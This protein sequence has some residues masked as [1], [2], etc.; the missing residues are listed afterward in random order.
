MKRKKLTTIT[1]ALAAL[2]VSTAL[3]GELMLKNTSA[4]EVATYELSTIFSATD[5]T[6]GASDSK[7][8]AFTLSDGGSVTFKR[9]L[10]Y[11][12]Y[13]AANTANYLTMKFAFQDTKFDAVEFEFDAP[14]AWATKDD[15]TTNVVQFK[16]A[17]DDYLVS[18]NGMEATTV[19]AADIA[20]DMT[21][22]LAEGTVDGEFTV[23]LKVGDTAAVMNEENSKFVNVGANYATYTYGETLPLTVSAVMPTSA[24]SDTTVVLFKELN[25]QK[26]DALTDENKIEDKTAPVLVV[27]E[28]IDGFLL[29]SAFALD[30]TVVDVLKKDS[31]TKNLTYYQYDP[32]KEGALTDEDYKTLDTSVYFMDTVFTDGETTTSVFSK[33]GQ[34]YV[35]VKAEIGDG[36][37]T[38][39]IDLS[40][41]AKRTVNTIGG[42]ETETPYIVIDRNTEGAKYVYVT[43]KESTQTNDF[44]E[45]AFEKYED[46]ENAGKYKDEAVNSFYE[47]LEEATKDVTAGS[48]SYVYFPSFKWFINDNNGYRNLKFTISYKT[49]S[50]SSAS[51]STGLSHSALKLAVSEEGT[52]QFKIF[53]T[54]KAGNT[55]KYY[56]ED[57]ELVDI[58]TDNVWDIEE[59]PYFTFS[60]DNQGLKV[61]DPSKASD[62]KDSVILNKTYTMDEIDVVGAS[63]MQESYSLYKVDMNAYNADAE[64]GRKLTQSALSAVSYEDIAT[65]LQTFKASGSAYNAEY[66]KAVE[67]KNYY[68]VYLL[69]YSKLLAEEIGAVSTDK[70]VVEKIKS[71]FVEIK[72]YDARINEENGATEWEAYNKY[73]WTPTSKSFSTVEEGSFLIVADYWEKLTPAVRAAA[74]KVIVVESEAD[75]IKGE[76]DWLKNNVVSVVLFSVAGVM[77]ILIIILLLVKPSDETLEDVDAKAAAKKKEAKNKK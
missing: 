63:N 72:E 54:D 59:I 56:N 9:N 40:W 15:K 62:R 46:G 73:N 66:L 67:S 32:D 14:S 50:S 76:T 34:E 31:L 21:L 20:K 27:N 33:Y 36:S 43:A 10:A 3:S 22:S 39:D 5:A 26:F 4:D 23:A 58:T 70:E 1:L 25:G 68:D 52:Y 71:C 28:E 37:N 30:Y 41:Y 11:K 53:A 12:W 16:K 17:S 8:T 7:V 77:L 51:A 42:T 45:T 29:G 61:E 60:I 24:E 35:S 55:M 57:N 65:E 19:A 75:T 2:T 6:L 48:N 38:S 44:N 47:A 74:Y 49:P 18:V 13:S 69:A 64:T